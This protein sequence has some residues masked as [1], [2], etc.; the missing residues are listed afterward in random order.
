[1]KDI[2][3]LKYRRTLE[4]L[5]QESQRS[6][7]KAVLSLSGGALGISF[8][9][10]SKFIGDSQVVCPGWLLTAW[11]SW[12]IS[13]TSILFSF[14]F[15]N[16]ALRKAINQVDSGTI[17]SERPGGLFDKVTATLNAFGGILFLIGVFSIIIFVS[18]NMEV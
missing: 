4:T 1:M 15:S 8:A 11:I 6:Y 5:K 3:N 2:N 17:Q 10:I 12:G 14:Y 16:I 7:D 13:I 18:A 9:F